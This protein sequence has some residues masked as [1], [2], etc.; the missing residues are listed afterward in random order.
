MIQSKSY[1]ASILKGLFTLT[2]LFGATGT[3]QADLPA[4]APAN[5]VVEAVKDISSND[6]TSKIKSTELD[7]SQAAARFSRITG[8]LRR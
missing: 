1:F 5:P 7:S 6:I 2:L 3:A 8:L 4:S